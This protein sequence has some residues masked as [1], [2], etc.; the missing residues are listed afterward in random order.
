MTE[1]R[2]SFRVDAQEAHLDWQKF[3]TVRFGDPSEPDKQQDFIV[4]EINIRL[5]CPFFEAA[6]S[7]DWK[8]AQ[9]RVVHLPEHTPDVFRIYLGWLYQKR[10]AMSHI[11]DKTGQPFR[12]FNMALCRAYL[13]G[14]YLEDIDFKDT[15]IDVLIDLAVRSKAYYANG[16]DFI[17]KNTPAESPLRRL[18]IDLLVYAKGLDWKKTSCDLLDVNFPAEAFADLVVKMD[19]TKN[20]DTTRRSKAPFFTDT[21]LYHCHGPD[22]ECYKVK[23]RTTGVEWKPQA[24]PKRRRLSA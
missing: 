3:I 7:R 6:L 1:A 4:H 21:C 14:D 20:M 15:V 13:L 8:E 19:E 17:Y 16:T 10:I 12:D 23:Y 9:E 18:V 24:T 5:Q 11:P 2:S 22:E